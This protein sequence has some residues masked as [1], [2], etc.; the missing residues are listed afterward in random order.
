[1]ELMLLII[2]R[3]DGEIVLNC[4]GGPSVIT[5]ALKS[6]RRQESLSEVMWEALN[7]LLLALKMEEGLEPKNVGSL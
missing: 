1:M 7:W 4:L 6:E 2:W 3:W 5:R